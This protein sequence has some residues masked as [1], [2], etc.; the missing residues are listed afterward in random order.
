MSTTLGFFNRINGSDRYELNQ[1]VTSPYETASLNAETMV[2]DITDFI[3]NNSFLIDFI[4][5]DYLMLLSFGTDN[6]VT[7]HPSISSVAYVNN[8]D[9]DPD[10]GINKVVITCDEEVKE[11]PVTTD[12][13]AYF[14]SLYPN[15]Y[16]SASS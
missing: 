3:Q 7:T 6:S 16:T 13:G 12:I 8:Q 4:E 11:M 2:R 15:G 14:K 10:N 9:A 1:I 5:S